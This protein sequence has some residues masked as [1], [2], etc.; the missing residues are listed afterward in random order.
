MTKKILI[1]LT[2]LILFSGCSNMLAEKT[3][4]LSLYE[5]MLNAASPQAY[6]AINGESVN[7]YSLT[8]YLNLNV[9]NGY[10]MRFS[11]DNSIWSEWENYSF[12]TNWNLSDGDGEKTV[13]AQVQKT[14]GD[15]LY[16]NDSIRYIN[17]IIPTDL[18]SDSFFGQSVSISSD[19]NVIAAGTNIGTGGSASIYKWYTANWQETKL[20]RPSSTENDF[21]GHAVSLNG[22]GNYA[23]AGA[24]GFNQIGAVYI[25]KQSLIITE[26]WD[27]VKTLSAGDGSV[28]D[29]F[30]Y[31]VSMSRNGSILA[32]GAPGKDSIDKMNTGTVYIYA[33]GSDDWSL[34]TTIT[35]DAIDQ[36][37]E[38]KFG[39]AVAVSADGTYIA[40]STPNASQFKGAVYVY[41]KSG[42]NYIKRKK[43]MADDS[44]INS[45]LGTSI[46]ISD[47]G[48]IISAGAPGCDIAGK[49]NQGAVY[50]FEH[51]GSTWIQI[52]KLTSS[53]G[54]SN[55]GFGN[56]VSLS[57]DG[58]FLCAGS[59]R[60]DFQTMSD[61]G[62][63]YIFN[64][65]AGIYTE[66]KKHIA[67]DGG[68]DFLLG[69]AV[70]ISYDG[71]KVK[72]AAGSKGDSTQ[73]PRKGS[74]Y[75]FS[76]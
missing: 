72:T 76:D 23:A 27:L 40:V 58:T 32:V 11:N 71:G 66:Y 37:A 10:K 46:S 38:D 51:N 24:Y 8:A 14:S 36:E 31:S 5:N 15:I 20:E 19:G 29:Y 28:D 33:K 4:D 13:F 50:I 7:L 47:N 25:F 6:F 18:N 67:L 41:E 48:L 62:A 43:L 34:I 57:F 9:T 1:I 53:D 12:I 26:P 16:F 30:G 55:D 60:S 3:A 22:S 68:T 52:K 61:S 45:L 63:V 75:V 35:A 42:N 65:N 17:K 54:L 2:F 64:R 39:T 56:S 69:S 73:I 74:V 49:V 70:A 21:Y 44:S 59:S